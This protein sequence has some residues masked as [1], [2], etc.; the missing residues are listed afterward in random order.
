MPKNYLGGLVSIFSYDQSKLSLL[1]ENCSSI[2]DGDS[3]VKKKGTWSAMETR[4]FTTGK[5]SSY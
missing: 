2:E 4:D 5:A 3:Q 1:D